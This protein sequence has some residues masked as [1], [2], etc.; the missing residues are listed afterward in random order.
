ME[1]SFNAITENRFLGKAMVRYSDILGEL[2]RTGAFVPTERLPFDVLQ[3][4]LLDRESS[5]A[6]ADNRR[7]SRICQFEVAAPNS[8]EISFGDRKA[9]VGCL[10]ER[11]KTAVNGCG[12]PRQVATELIDNIEAFK[13]AL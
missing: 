11:L 5:Y 2:R 13:G 9:F 6:R 12:L 1:I 8:A 3:V 10:A 4:I 7:E